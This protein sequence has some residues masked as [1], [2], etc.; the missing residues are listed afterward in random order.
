MAHKRPSPRQRRKLRKSRRPRRD[1]DAPENRPLP[2][3]REKQA[4]RLNQTDPLA[5]A[6]R[7]HLAKYRPEEFRALCQAGGLEQHLGLS[8]AAARDQGVRLA[9]A[10]WHPLEAQEYAEQEN[11]FRESEQEEAERLASLPLED[12][13]PLLS[14]RPP[15]G[16]QPLKKRSPPP[17]ATAGPA[18]T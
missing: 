10:G 6:G 12:A 4:A 3:L 2:L 17:Q 1:L 5:A 13:P 15:P 9:L 18:T 16:Q 11:V 14:H 8:A 7:D